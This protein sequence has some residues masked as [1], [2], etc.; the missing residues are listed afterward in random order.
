M[1]PNPSQPDSAPL[2]LGLLGAGGFAQFVG[3]AIASIPE[4]TVSAVAD[5][6]SGR[7]EHLAKRFDAR[8]VSAD[9]LISHPEVD[10][11]VIA[12]PPALHAEQ[13]LAAL[14]AGKHVFCEKPASLSS[15]QMAEVAAEAEA[16]G[17]TYALDHVIHHNPL[18]L[19]L[20]TLREQGL[21]GEVQR[22]VF[23]ND[24]GDSGLDPEHWFWDPEHSGGIFLE[25]AVHFFDVARVLVG[26]PERVVQAM[27]HERP[28]GRV[29]TVVATVRHENGALATHAHGFSHDNL[30][31][32]QL[33][34]VDFGPAEARL[35]GW[36]PLGLS[37]DAWVDDEVLD[38][39]AEIAQHP[40][41]WLAVPGF[42]AGPNQGA[43]LWV[44]RD[45]AP[46]GLHT[47]DVDLPYKHHVGL[48][49]A[50][51]QPQDKQQVYSSSVR[52]ALVDFVNC[53]RTGGVP[54]AGVA[55]GIATVSVASAA[56]RALS[57]GA[58]EQV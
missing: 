17:L 56:T 14:R 45:A 30:T 37:L 36:I 32:R 5:L 4:L 12:T 44:D 29:D 58:T 10:A 52:A 22:F 51:G 42:Q 53:V 15:E 35:V 20:A 23:E 26:S 40:E 41:R 16:R 2:R 11:V 31:E 8:Y 49:V 19:L 27:Q 1:T 47:H 55:E 57:S 25:H 6:S 50:L 9:E 7:G 46:E 3:E 18:V 43:E 38:A 33:M 21:L 24:A 28:D 39:L 13:S 34:R 54:R 48:Y